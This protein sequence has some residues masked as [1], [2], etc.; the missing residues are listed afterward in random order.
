MSAE[1]TRFDASLRQVF[2]P[3]LR[4]GYQLPLQGVSSNPLPNCS[5][6]AESTHFNSGAVCETAPLQ[7]HGT[8]PVVSAMV[9][10]GDARSMLL[11][12]WEKM[13]FEEIEKP[14]EEMDTA[15]LLLPMATGALDTATVVASA[16][17]RDRKSTR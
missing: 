8:T 16:V 11:A 9:T 2:L 13:P 4:S 1:Q 17:P 10:L 14:L 3:L 6:E 12:P 15:P 7:T 5:L